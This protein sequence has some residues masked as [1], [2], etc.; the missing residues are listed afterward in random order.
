MKTVAEL[1]F[2]AFMAVSGCY[3]VVYI[4][5]GLT[6]NLCKQL[7]HTPFACSAKK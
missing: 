1:I 5:D 2:F 4:T 3:L 6:A 7:A